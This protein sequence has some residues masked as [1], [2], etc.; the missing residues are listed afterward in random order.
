MDLFAKRNWKRY[1]A[2]Q[3]QKTSGIGASKRV[4]FLPLRKPQPSAVGEWEF[5]ES[6]EPKAEE[7]L[8]F[9]GIATSRPSLPVG[10]AKFYSSAGPFFFALGFSVC[11]WYI[12]ESFAYY[13]APCD[14]LGTVLAWKEPLWQIMFAVMLKNLFFDSSWVIN[15]KKVKPNH[16]YLIS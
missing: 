10:F 16:Q 1:T 5:P 4:E 11:W 9:K 2:L 7:I 13:A 12:L 8:C 14:L 3:N 6:A 15:S